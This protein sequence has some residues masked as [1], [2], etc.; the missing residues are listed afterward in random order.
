MKLTFGIITGG[1]Q[2]DFINKIIDSIEEEKIPDYEI[3]VVGS[4]LSARKHTIMYL[5][6]EEMIPMWITKKKNVIAQAAKGEI[7]VLM[8]DYIRLEK[9]WYEGFLR[10]QT[11]NPVWDV[12]M[13]KLNDISGLRLI[14]WIGLAGD[15]LYGNVLLPYEYSNP[16]GMYVPGNFFMVKRDFLRAH[17]L[18]ERRNWGMGEDI[19]WSKRIFGGI[20]TSPWIR[21]LLVKPL[22]I[23]IPDPE[24]P[25][26][27]HMNIYSTV[28]C[29][30]EKHI[31]PRYRH[32]YDTH[33]PDIERPIGYKLEDY[34]YMQKR[35]ERKIE[36]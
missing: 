25:A 21:N 9:G 30:K 35:L 22:D 8:H 20:D 28:V 13:C 12:A 19:E 23:E 29:M 6:P 24:S 7:L 26:Q 15:K 34:V 33:S 32:E 11:E 31:H 3:L 27:Y 4:F 2:D 16:K 14:D 17:P 10:F 36:S 1:D 18:D 5:F